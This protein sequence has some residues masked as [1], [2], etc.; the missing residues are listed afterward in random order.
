MPQPP[1]HPSGQPPPP[2]VGVAPSD[3]YEPKVFP[4]GLPQIFFDTSVISS[5]ASRGTYD[6][7]VADEIIASRALWRWRGELFNPVVS[8]LI[9][10][11][12]ERGDSQAAQRRIAL[13]GGIGVLHTT[14]EIESLAE[15]LC[16]VK[17]FH[18]NP[19]KA[20]HPGYDLNGIPNDAFH[21]AVTA[22]YRVPFLTSFDNDLVA[23][24]KI[25]LIESACKET[26]Y[27]PPLL[28]TPMDRRLLT[29]VQ[30]HANTI[31]RGIKP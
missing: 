16:L 13:V 4:T 8:A 6:S 10:N 2:L 31:T 24:R 9:V 20:G 17:V 25:A 3:L 5:I 21:V 30:K 1:P 7:R 15:F 11:E 26:G 28:L 12:L 22:F 18:R 27:S 14:P 29:A 23:N 19:D